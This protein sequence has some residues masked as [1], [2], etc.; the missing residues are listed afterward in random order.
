MSFLLPSNHL[1]DKTKLTRWIRIYNHRQK[2]CVCFP[3][4]NVDLGIT[5]VL[6]LQNRRGSTLG[7]ERAHYSENKGVGSKS[8]EFTRKFKRNG[9]CLNYL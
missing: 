9:V 2:S 4:P 3:F 8:Q 5:M 7:R 1:Y 6:V